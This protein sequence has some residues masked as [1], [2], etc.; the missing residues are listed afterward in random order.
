M[1]RSVSSHPLL[2]VVLD[3][4][5][6][7]GNVG[8]I[9]RL[10]ATCGAALHVCN[11]GFTAGS[12]LRRPGLD[13]WGDARVHFHDDLERCLRLLGKEPWVV[14][15]GGKKAPWDAPFSLGDV[16]VL[17]PEDGSVELPEAFARAD[18]ER[19][20]TLPSRPGMRSLNVAQCTAVV[21]YEAVRQ[22]S[23]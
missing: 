18:N 4:P 8:A 20:L 1:I 7:A 22:L 2:H 16:V 9:A 5:K 13:Y 6:I 15:V 12:D 19:I 17:G 11:A 10:V 23:L 14:E 21:V 3:R